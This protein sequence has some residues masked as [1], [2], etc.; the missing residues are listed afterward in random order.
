MP[1]AGLRD[2]TYFLGVH[3][4]WEQDS[5]RASRWDANEIKGEMRIAYPHIR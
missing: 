3:Q 4:R 2:P 1:H 5:D